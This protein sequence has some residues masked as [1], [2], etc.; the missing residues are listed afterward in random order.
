MRGRSQPEVPALCD[1]GVLT[2]QQEG[3]DSVREPPTAAAERKMRKVCYVPML[4][5]SPATSNADEPDAVP[6][7]VAMGPSEVAY[8]LAPMHLLAF[9]AAGGL[10]RPSES[11]AFL[12]SSARHLHKSP[13]SEDWGRTPRVGVDG[14]LRHPN[15]VESSLSYNMIEQTT[16]AEA[17]S[18][19]DGDDNGPGSEPPPHDRFGYV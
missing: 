14:I 6:K 15:A 9:H 3:E 13:E 12:A 8:A 2:L 4:R 1:I 7:I 18:G 19:P 17:A 10:Q 5:R 16:R 11:R